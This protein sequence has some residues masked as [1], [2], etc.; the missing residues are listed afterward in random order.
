MRAACL[1]C[2]YTCFVQ[3]QL[4]R[5]QLRNADTHAPHDPIFFLANFVFFANVGIFSPKM[6]YFSLPRYYLP[7]AGI[8]NFVFFFTP[9]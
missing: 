5:R 6:I 9:D 1:S 7:A 4:W 8:A 2:L 3:R